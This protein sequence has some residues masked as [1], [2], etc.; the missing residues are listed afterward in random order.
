MIRRDIDPSTVVYERYLDAA[1]DY[2]K[3]LVEVWDK[4]LDALLVFVSMAVLF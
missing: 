4:G 1:R 3:H 2:D